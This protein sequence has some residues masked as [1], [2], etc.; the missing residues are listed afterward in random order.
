[1]QEASRDKRARHIAHRTRHVSFLSFTYPFFFPL[2]HR[3]TPFFRSAKNL[4]TN[5][6]AIWR[7]VMRLLICLVLLSVENNGLERIS[8]LRAGRHR[9]CR[10]TL[11][12][13]NSIVFLFSVSIIDL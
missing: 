6:R 10:L 13:P 5:L 12:L 2:L 3:W 8:I 9:A 7:F 4:D 1:M 11:I